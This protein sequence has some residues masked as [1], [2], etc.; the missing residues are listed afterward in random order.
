MKRRS[1]R[2]RDARVAVSQRIRVV[3][4]LDSTREPLHFYFTHKNI[5]TL[6]GRAQPLDWTRGVDGSRA[7]RTQGPLFSNSKNY[8][9]RHL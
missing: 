9:L 1:R 8:T 7:A 4:K 6:P 2:F 5:T 3:D